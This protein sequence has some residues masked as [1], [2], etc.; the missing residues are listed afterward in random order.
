MRARKIAERDSDGR[1][2]RW[3]GLREVG[4]SDWHKLLVFRVSPSSV[5]IVALYDM[6]QDLSVV[7]PEAD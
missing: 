3:P 5:T 6:R 7:S 1:I 4:L 2:S